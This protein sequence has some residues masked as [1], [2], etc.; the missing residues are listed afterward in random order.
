MATANHPGL[1]SE[2]AVV[3]NSQP[4]ANAYHQFAQRKM[5]RDEALDDYF[6]NY[7]KNINPAGMRQQDVEG[8]MMKQKEW[9]QFYQQN[10]DAIKNP[11]VDN[12]KA[13]TEY[14]SRYQDQLSYIEQSKERAAIKKQLGQARLNPNLSYVFDDD[15]IIQQINDDDKPLN[16]P[17]HKPI[18]IYQL[19]IQPK[20]FGLKERQTFQKSVTAG[21][22]P[23]EE[24]TGITNDPKT[25]QDIV[26]YKST[27]SPQDLQTIGN[28]A[29]TFYQSDPS[30]RNY[31][32]KNLTDPNNFSQLNEV[33]Q[34]TYGQPAETPADLFV[35][36]TISNS[37]STGTKQK[38]TASSLAKTLAVEAVKQGNR[39]AMANMKRAWKTADKQQEI[40]IENGYWETLEEDALKNPVK[41]RENGKEYTQ[42]E[43]KS[44]PQA[45][46]I[47]S[48]T[49][50]KEGNYQQLDAIRLNPD[51]TVEGIIYKRDDDGNIVK[52]DK[53]F[54]VVKTTSKKLLKSDFRVRL[55]KSV[56]G[57]KEAKAEQG[58]TTGGA[59]ATPAKKHPLPAGKPRTVKQNGHTY[60]WNEQTGEYE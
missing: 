56:F 47:L 26:S 14:Q 43:M 23:S 12:G 29:R 57:T 50:D 21:L 60:T 38:P 59:A 19:K 10:R 31:A 30:I 11:R 39:V 28:R 35:A 27:Y 51:N 58:K 5:A 2:G 32:N 3:L 48:P 18:D 41:V 7:G 37:I 52:D 53:G 45:D 24:V 40:A 9:N 4:A 44:S 1:F 36:E 16:D 17:T 33:Y 6:R 55:I 34:K 20:P 54:N 46:A 8:L 25:L 22:K 42:Y 15:S 49:K 13:L